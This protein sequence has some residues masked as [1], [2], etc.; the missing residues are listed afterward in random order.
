LIRFVQEVKLNPLFP[1]CGMQLH[2]HIRIPKMD[3]SFPYRSPCHG[4]SSKI[5]LH[6]KRDN[7]N[8]LF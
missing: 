6:E 4:K 2:R 8:L 1:D 3:I 7:N 5:P